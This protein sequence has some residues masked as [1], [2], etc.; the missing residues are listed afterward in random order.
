MTTP[1]HS[2]CNAI[3]ANPFSIARGP[4]LVARIAPMRWIV[5]LAPLTLAIVLFP[6]ACRDRSPVAPIEISALLSDGA[7]GGGNPDFF[8]LPPLVGDPTS[9]RNFTP[10]QFNGRL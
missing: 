4:T 8:F 5:R 2:L 7:H 9:S 10:G 6:A 1:G 3:P